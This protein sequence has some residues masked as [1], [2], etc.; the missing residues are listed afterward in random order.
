M[1][2]DNYQGNR[3]GKLNG[4]PVYKV[5]VGQWNL[6]DTSTHECF[7][8]VGDLLFFHD[9]KVGT[10]SNGGNVDLDDA[11]IEALKCKWTYSVYD[12]PTKTEKPA[13]THPVEEPKPD[14]DPAE[15]DRPHDELVSAMLNRA[16]WTVKDMLKGCNMAADEFLKTVKEA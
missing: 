15:P 10:V 11:K 9:V 12:K 7:Y 1:G 16:A 4:M 2:Y 3:V 13:E 6:S 14:N 5:S 8:W